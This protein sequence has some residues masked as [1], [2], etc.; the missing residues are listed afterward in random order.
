MSVA[1]SLRAACTF[2]NAA[3]VPWLLS[4]WTAVAMSSRAARAAPLVAI[5]STVPTAWSY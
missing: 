1:S 4:A 2:A 5:V 3:A